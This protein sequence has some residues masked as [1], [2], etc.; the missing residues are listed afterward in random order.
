LTLKELYLKKSERLKEDGE[1]EEEQYFNHAGI[2]AESEKLFV[3]P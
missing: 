2:Y 3:V 1:S